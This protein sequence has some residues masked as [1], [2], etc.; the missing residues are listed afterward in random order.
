MIYAVS[1]A[2]TQSTASGK[3]LLSISELLQIGSLAGHKF[4]RSLDKKLEAQ[5]LNNCSRA[6]LQALFLLVTGT[7]LAIGYTEPAANKASSGNVSAP[8]SKMIEN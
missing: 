5:S 2:Y 7:I 8:P 4:L 6:D 1:R 3:H